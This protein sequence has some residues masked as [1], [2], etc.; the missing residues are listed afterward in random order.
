[1]ATS[2][3][4]EH[5]A[6]LSLVPYLK[7]E[8]EKSFDFVVPL[9]PWLNRETSNI[10]K[11][12]HLNDSFKVLVIFP[13]RPKLEQGDSK[14]VFVTINEDL[15]SFKEFANAYDVPVIAGCPI[16]TNFW[17]LSKCTNHVWIEINKK[18]TRTYLY[19]ISSGQNKKNMKNLSISSIVQMVN[20]S[21]LF[22][23]EDFQE[24]LENSKNVMPGVFLFGP[25]YK[26]TYLLIRNR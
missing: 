17:E 11:H 1:M 9:F 18:T 7:K 2:F 25:R 24:F 4:N 22:S 13:R 10:S 15:L 14:N 23:I 21:K 3:I 8:L 16:A 12:V 19:H 26:P 20:K 6:E 5:S